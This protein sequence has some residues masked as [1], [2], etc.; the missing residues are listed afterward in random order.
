MRTKLLRSHKGFTLVELLIGMAI[1]I[2]IL[3][4]AYV[5]FIGSIKFQKGQDLEV[6]MQQNARTAADFIVRELRNESAISCLEGSATTCSTSGDKINFTSMAD[7]DTRIFS[8][9]NS[10]NILRFSKSGAGSP[11]RQPL[12]DNIT[13][14]SFTPLYTTSN[15]LANVYG[16]E[17]NITARSKTIDPATNNY[18]TFTFKTSVMKRN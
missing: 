9:S 17:I 13:A 8:W 5:L 2:I 15:S 6:E 14:F 4:A 1:F 3:S 10:D 7:G 18:H 12:A 11:D 16:V